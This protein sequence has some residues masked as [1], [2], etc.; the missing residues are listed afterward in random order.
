LPSQPKEAIQTDKCLHSIIRSPYPL[1]TLLT[2]PKREHYN[3]TFLPMFLFPICKQTPA[4]NTRK[5]VEMW[6]SPSRQRPLTVQNILET[7]SRRLAPSKFRIL[8]ITPTEYQ[9]TFTSSQSERETVISCRDGPR[10]PHFC[11]HWKFQS[12][13]AR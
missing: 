1:H 9:V 4:Q 7:F 11:D 2:V 13:P 8:Q 10:Q 12:H 3:S 5:D 6:D